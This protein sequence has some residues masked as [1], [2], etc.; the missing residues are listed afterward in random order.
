MVKSS[1]WAG[2]VGLGLVLIAAVVTFLGGRS[3]NRCILPPVKGQPPNAVFGIIWPILFVLLA[4]AGY[5]I[6]AKAQSTASRVLFIFVLLFISVYPFIAWAAC[7]ATFVTFIIVLGLVTL[8]A[9]MIIL[10]T[11]ELGALFL[12]IPLAVWLTYASILSY[13]ST[14]VQPLTNPVEIAASLNNRFVS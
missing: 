11:K 7:S 6:F 9:L 1:T 4:I 12:L 8:I 10:V 14:K 3:R 13:R 5:R 2:W